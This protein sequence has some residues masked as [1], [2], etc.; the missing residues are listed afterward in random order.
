MSFGVSAVIIDYSGDLTDYT[1][2][3]YRFLQV[4]SDSEINTKSS[5]SWTALLAVFTLMSLCSYIIYTGIEEEVITSDSIDDSSPEDTISEDEHLREIALSEE[6]DDE[7][8][9]E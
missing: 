1:I 5:G 6:I 3:V 9:L 7:K 4:E 8:D 2:S